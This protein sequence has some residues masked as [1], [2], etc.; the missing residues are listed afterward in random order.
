MGAERFNIEDKRTIANNLFRKADEL[1]QQDRSQFA[2]VID[3][4]FNV[5][6]I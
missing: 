6:K 3:T 5:F 2:K 4:Y 1:W